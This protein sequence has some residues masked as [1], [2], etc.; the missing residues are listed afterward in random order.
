M[1][2]EAKELHFDDLG[3]TKSLDKMTAKELRALVVEKIP[4]ITG[5]SGMD[6]DQLVAAI[7]EVFGMTDEEGSPNP[8]KGQISSIKR[9]IRE[10][11]AQKADVSA[12]QDRDEL[13]KKINKLKKRT[14]RLAKAG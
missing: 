5:A 12:R 2:E 14:R 7:K 13:R 8:Y 11:R 3:L 10:L 1:S 6:K 4:M 9:E